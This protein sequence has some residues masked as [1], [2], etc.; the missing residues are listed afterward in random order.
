MIG[1]LAESQKIYYSKLKVCNSVKRN[2]QVCVCEALESRRHYTYVCRKTSQIFTH[3]SR[4]VILARVSWRA[5]QQGSSPMK[6]KTRS[7]RHQSLGRPGTQRDT[8]QLHLRGDLCTSPAGR[9]QHSDLQTQCAPRFMCITQ[10]NH[11]S[12]QGQDVIHSL[13][14]RNPGLGR[15][16]ALL[17]LHS[18]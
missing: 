10:F 16:N 4:W 3:I 11:R 5:E 17:R 14:T 9:Q 13:W 8:K 15:L 1:D 2:N 18:S 7:R 6:N 12:I